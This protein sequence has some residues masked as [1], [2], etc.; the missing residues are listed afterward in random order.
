MTYPDVE[1]RLW[2]MDYVKLWTALIPFAKDQTWVDAFKRPEKK[3]ALHIACCSNNQVAIRALFAMGAGH[4]A[5]FW[6]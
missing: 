6:V 3:T 1:N 4:L 2:W 5:E